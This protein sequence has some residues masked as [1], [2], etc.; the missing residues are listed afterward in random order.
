MP[1]SNSHFYNFLAKNVQEFFFFLIKKHCARI[2]KNQF[3][4]F[5]STLKFH[6][7]VFGRLFNLSTISAR[8]S[9][10]FRM[11]EP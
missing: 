4:T 2:E 6:F 5:Q 9:V 11:L 1:F 7:S 3:Q 8:Q 10:N